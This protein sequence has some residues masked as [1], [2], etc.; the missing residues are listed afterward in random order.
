MDNPENKNAQTKGLSAL[1]SVGADTQSDSPFPRL[2]QVR[3]GILVP[4]EQWVRMVG[5]MNEMA[6]QAAAF[7]DYGIE[8]LD[9]F[10]GDPD[11]EDSDADED[12]DPSGQCDEDG[13]NTAYQAAGGPGCPIADP[14]EDE[15]AG[16]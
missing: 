14:G 1:V 10:D 15:D 7:A 16:E 2:T 5:F 12:D 3:S 6:T 9:D 8:R 11:C 4:V 13:I